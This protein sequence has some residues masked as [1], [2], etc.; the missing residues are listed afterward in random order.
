M[1]VLKF[2]STVDPTS[3]D[4]GYYPLTMTTSTLATNIALIGN[5]TQVD[6]VDYF[7]IDI[8]NSTALIEQASY[9]P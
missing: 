5:L 6:T 3:S 2:F 1:D 9:Q 8:S 7:Y 4:I